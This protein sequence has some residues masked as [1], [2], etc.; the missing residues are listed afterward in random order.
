MTC[1]GSCPSSGS[2]CT[3]PSRAAESTRQCVTRKCLGCGPPD[4]ALLAP[5]REAAAGGGPQPPPQAGII[6]LFRCGMLIAWARAM[7][8]LLP[9]RSPAWRLLAIV[10]PT[11][12]A[13]ALGCS[14]EGGREE[15]DQAAQAVDG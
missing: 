11:L 12:V 3:P 7:P 5:S 15:V 13:P 1:D 14:D 4:D 10:L 8:K 6:T 2:G 9:G